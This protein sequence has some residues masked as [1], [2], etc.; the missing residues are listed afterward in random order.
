MLGVV[1]DLYL[2]EDE[3]LQSTSSGPSGTGG[4]LL[5]WSGSS[6]LDGGTVRSLSQEGS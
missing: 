6:L 4:V 3:D 1:D 2:P 5:R